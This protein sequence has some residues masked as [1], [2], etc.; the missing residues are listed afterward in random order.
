M[1]GSASLGRRGAAG[2]GF[3]LDLS[4]FSFVLTWDLVGGGGRRT[5]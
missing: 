2:L 5:G 4:F 1:A 3:G